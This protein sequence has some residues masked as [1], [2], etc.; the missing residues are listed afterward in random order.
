TSM[1]RGSFNHDRER[2]G[3]GMEWPGLTA[4]DKWRQQEAA[5]YGIEI[6]SSS[7]WSGPG[8]WK[9]RRLYVC[10]RAL[11]GGQSKYTPKHL[12]RSRKLPSKKIG[13]P[14]QIII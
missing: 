8:L 9:E 2:G 7:T 13:C 6:I 12:E 5:A 14:C 4:F 10:S 11:S 3:Y 1:K